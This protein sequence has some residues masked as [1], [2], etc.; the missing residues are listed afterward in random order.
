VLDAPAQCWPQ[1]GEDPAI[2]RLGDLVG[3][4]VEALPGLHDVVD[5]LAELR[6]AA[7][8]PGRLRPEHRV[9]S[10]TVRAG[11]G[12]DRISV[13]SVESLDQFL[14]DLGVLLRPRLRGISRH[15]EVVGA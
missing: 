8:D 3:L 5:P 12:D 15:G 9:L 10:F 4:D 7:V 13:S 6:S 1:A 11:R 2:T 14:G